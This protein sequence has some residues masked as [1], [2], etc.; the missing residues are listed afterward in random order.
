MLTILNAREDL[1][2][3]EHLFIAGGNATWHSPF[4]RQF[5]TKLNIFSL[6]DL[7]IT[8]LVLTQRK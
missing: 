3:Y 2:K 1:E 8:L 7:E 5:S 4:G 6:Y